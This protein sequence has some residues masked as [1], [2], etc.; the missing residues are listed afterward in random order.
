VK[1]RDLAWEDYPSLVKN[2]LALYEEVRDNPDV[3]ISLFPRPP[4]LGEEAEWFSGMY[5]AVQDG[6]SIAVVAEDAGRAIGICNVR[7]MGQLE[8][9]HLGVLGILVARGERHRGVGKALMQAALE[10]CRGKFDLVEL[11]VFETNTVARRLYE[12]LGFRVWGTLPSAIKRN[13]RYIDAVHM[14]LDLR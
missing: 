13:S 3:G 7:R 12:S 2:Y 1:I 14:I 11:S 4:T 10:R 9:Q 8:N 6:S 5:Q